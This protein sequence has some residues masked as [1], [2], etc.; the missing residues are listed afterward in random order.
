MFER[1]THRLFVLAGITAA[2]ALADNNSTESIN[3]AVEGG[4]ASFV[5]NT[6][7]AAIS[8]KGKSAALKARVNLRRSQEGLQLDRI[9]A[10]IPVKS[11]VTGMGVR[12][13]HMRKYIFT[14]ADGKTPDIRFQGENATCSS[15]GSGHEST[16]QVAGSLSIRGVARPFTI[17]LKIREE[18]T[19]FKAIG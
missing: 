5:A 1:N 8:V 9:E 19:A 16:C 6:N 13:D 11:L 17:P 12:D 18:G 14:T 2:L 10:L 15:A 4:T 7:V 3:I